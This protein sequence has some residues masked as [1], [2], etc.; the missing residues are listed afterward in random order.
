[1]TLMSVLVKQSLWKAERP[2]PGLVLFWMVMLT[3]FGWMGYRAGQ[4]A[5]KAK[6]TMARAY[7]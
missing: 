2:M 5:S 4:N 6:K 1:M 7:N 3:P